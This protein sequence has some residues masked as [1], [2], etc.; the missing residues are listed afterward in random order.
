MLASKSL[1]WVEQLEKLETEARW[2]KQISSLIVEGENHCNGTITMNRSIIQQNF[3]KVIISFLVLFVWGVHAYIYVGSHGGK[4]LILS[5]YS[6]SLPYSLRQHLSSG[7]YW[8]G[9]NWL[10]SKPWVS[11]YLCLPSTGN[12]G[13]HYCAW[14]GIE[15]R[16]LGFH[17]EAL[18]HLDHLPNTSL[19]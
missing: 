14:L 3:K 5:V 10:T 7:A 6:F 11:S 12:S 15:L 17:W 4:R 18:Y 13:M 8:F 1:S 9:L 2:W 16:F 19:L